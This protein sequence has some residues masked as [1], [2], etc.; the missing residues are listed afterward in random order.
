MIVYV[1][2]KHDMWSDGDSVLDSV[3]YNEED[4]LKREQ[5]IDHMEGFYGS[6][7]EKEVK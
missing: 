5:K 7:E 6:T 1:V 2:M 4:A 3:W